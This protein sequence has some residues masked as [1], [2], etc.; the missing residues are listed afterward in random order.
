MKTLREYI[1]QLDEITRRDF[2]RGAGAALGSVVLGAP[3]VAVGQETPG[4]YGPT[5]DINK[6]EI[7]S[8]PDLNAYYPSFSKRAKEQGSVVVRLTIDETGIVE[9]TQLVQSSP[10]IQL[11]R[12]AELIGKKMRFKPYL[13]N[14]TPT[15][16]YSN[17]IVKFALPVEATNEEELDENS[18]D[19]VARILEL[20]KK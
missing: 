16:V 3:K 17:M 8:Q 12:A 9:N 7:I 4:S 10:Y 15:K 6:L 2:L 14:G 1:D 5:V 20:S 13:I 18:E 11:N 19:A